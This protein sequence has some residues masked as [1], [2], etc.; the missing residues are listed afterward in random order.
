MNSL[1]NLFAV[2]ALVASI[3]FVGCK[4]DDP[5]SCSDWAQQLQDELNAYSQALNEWS[6]DPTN[7]A[8]CNA[9]RDA[10]QDYLDEA[11]GLEECASNA[12][13]GTQYQQAID[14]A[15]DAL[16]NFQC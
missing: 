2:L 3:G 8:K 5:V 12:G 9:Y 10:L 1:K 6:A 15:Q 7:D 13:Q 11:E 14:A 4:D 16:D